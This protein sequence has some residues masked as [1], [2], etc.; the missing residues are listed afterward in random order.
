MSMD[1]DDRTFK[2]NF[3][4]E[5][6]E[7]LRV[8][9]K[10][11]L[12]EF[13]G[14]YTDD[15]L[16]EYVVV[17]LR[18]GRRKEEARNE[19]DVFLGD[20][21]GSFITW[22]W[23]HLAANL[24]LYVKPH[25]P[26]GNVL[27]KIKPLIMD[28]AAK[29][30][31]MHPDVKKEGGKSGKPSRSRH[32]REWKDLVR[33]AGEPPPLRST[34]I[35]KLPVEE[36]SHLR[37]RRVRRSISPENYLERKRKR[38]DERPHAKREPTSKVIDAPRRL[39]QFAVRDAVAMSRTSE[40]AVGQAPKRLRS[41]LSTT[42]TDVDHPQK[43]QSIVRVRNPMST[44]IKAV[45]EA[46]QDVQRVR[47]SGNVFDRISCA[48]DV[49]ESHLT[50]HD[51]PTD[52]AGYGVLN[53]I[54][55]RTH[56]QKHDYN[57]RYV[58]DVMGL[59]N[60][61]NLIYDDASDREG[62]DDPRVGG[63]NV[64]L[65]GIFSGIKGESLGTTFG[66]NS[67]PE[68]VD[69]GMKHEYHQAHYMGLP[70]RSHGNLLKRRDEQSS[71]KHLQEN[72]AVGSKEGAEVEASKHSVTNGSGPANTPN[73]P[74]KLFPPTAGSS[75]AVHSLEDSDSRT[76]FVSN[77]NSAATKDNLYQL[78]KK[79]GEL[80]KVVINTDATTGQ[81]LGSAVIEFAH[82]DAAENALSLN[83]TSFLSR[84]IKVVKRSS[85]LQQAPLTPWPRALR[86]S[87]YARFSWVP[88]ARGGIPAPFRS[89]LPL[90]LG[91]RSLQWKRDSQGSATESSGCG[92]SPVMPATRKF[93]YV[94]PEPKPGSGVGSS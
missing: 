20:D 75:S 59:E 26:D 60:E 70:K 10:E 32:D 65:V 53:E 4:G 31:S 66:S 86:A 44:V 74:K 45:A 69:N 50:E 30:V 87:P 13:M 27:T 21:S 39:L 54:P 55:Q 48:S 79:F 17:L 43:V 3:T 78:F 61:T 23:D 19:L 1:M 15:T 76:I 67:I 91:A 29:V 56:L 68:G 82:K 9:V 37:D 12:K 11:K 6:A 85:S 52:G 33:F 90:R 5:G 25:E 18:N 51:H 41:V 40:S 8:A 7:R 22:L 28:Q 2:V 93:T 62:F 71:L 58:E 57:Q 16:V 64:S 34:E 47:P 49:P 35:E 38:T 84:I 36:E 46:A 72:R 77:V 81:P 63:D 80:I 42:T 89:R 73:E 83:G 14:D 24:H 94:R 88:Y 92:S